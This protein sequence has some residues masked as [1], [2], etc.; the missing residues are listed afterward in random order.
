LLTTVIE[1]SQ[2]ADEGSL[3][4]A[5]FSFC[6]NYKNM[7]AVCWTCR[8]LRE[9]ARRSC[10]QRQSHRL[11]D[12]AAEAANTS[13]LAATRKHVLAMQRHEHVGKQRQYDSDLQVSLDRGGGLLVEGVLQMIYST[14]TAVNTQVSAGNALTQACG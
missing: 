9:G 8:E 13:K 7:P 3:E 14:C 5:I 4:A 1:A 2:K 6:H 11:A 10:E 12:A